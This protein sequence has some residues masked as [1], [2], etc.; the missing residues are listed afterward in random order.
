MACDPEE[1]ENVPLFSLLDPDEKA[2]LAAQVELR[3]FAAR[4][5][6]YK[7]GDPGGKAY[8]VVSGGVRL[9]MVDEDHQ[10][11]V[12]D[13]VGH[14]EFFG[15]A[16]ML[17]QTPHQTDAHA[18]GESVCVEVDGAT[19]SSDRAQAACGHGYAD[20]AGTPV[21]RLAAT[22]KTRATRNPNDVIEARETTWA[23]ASPTGWRV[24]RIVVVHHCVFR[25]T[26][27]LYLRSM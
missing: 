16:S 4:E 24:W 10:E 1:L 26:H 15:F 8:V 25:G 19:L 17:D 12:V 6:I 13:Q 23:N 20:R 2:I 21:S 27:D 7:I 9:T 3:R 5:R 18:M 22:G 14:G 11:V